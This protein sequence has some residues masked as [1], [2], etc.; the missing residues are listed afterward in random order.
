MFIF[1]ERKNN[2]ALKKLLPLLY[3]IAAFS[4]NANYWTQKASFPTSGIIYTFSFSI[5]N[6]GYAGCGMDNMGNYQN[7]FWEYDPVSDAWTQKAFW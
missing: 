2:R 1:D 5:G 6:K 7:A 4:A 3:I